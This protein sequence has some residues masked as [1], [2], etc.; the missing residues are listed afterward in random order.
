[1]L[2]ARASIQSPDMVPV[3]ITV[4]MSLKEWKIVKKNLKNDPWW[5]SQF[6]SDTITQVEQTIF[7]EREKD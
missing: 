6:I 5:Y 7:T 2:Q 3:T 1:M 4:T